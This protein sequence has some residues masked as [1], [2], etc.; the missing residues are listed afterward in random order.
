VFLQPQCYVLGFWL[1]CIVIANVFSRHCKMCTIVRKANKD[2]LNVC[3]CAQP[4]ATVPGWLESGD[5]TVRSL[6]LLSSIDP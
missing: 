4:Y 5:V 6:R 3:C 2:S 1:T